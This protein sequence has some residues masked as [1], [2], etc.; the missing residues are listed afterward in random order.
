LEST[1]AS[2][3]TAT[4][5]TSAA[6]VGTGSINAGS[7]D[8][9]QTMTTGTLV[10]DDLSWID[11]LSNKNCVQKNNNYATTTVHRFVAFMRWYNNNL[12]DEVCLRMSL[13]TLSVKNSR[14]FY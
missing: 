2:S 14:A 4:P 3:T 6:T 12:A 7:T 8:G 5:T 10:D 11:E 13:Q 9:D 1:T